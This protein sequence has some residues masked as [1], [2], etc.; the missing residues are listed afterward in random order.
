M[1][2]HNSDV[3]KELLKKLFKVFDSEPAVAVIKLLLRDGPMSFRAIG[4]KLHINYRKLDKILKNLVD[5]NIL[6]VRIV[7]VSPTKR[8]KFYSLNE[9][10]LDILRDIV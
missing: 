1:S 6:E 2:I 7:S 4:R 3:T 10:Y 5:T 8:Y 9:R